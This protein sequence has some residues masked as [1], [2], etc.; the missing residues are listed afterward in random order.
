MTTSDHQFTYKHMLRTH[1]Y[2][3]PPDTE[4]ISECYMK[5]IRPADRPSSRPPV[6]GQSNEDWG[7]NNGARCPT[8]FDGAKGKQHQRDSRSAMWT[9]THKSIPF[10]DSTLSATVSGMPS[11]QAVRR[12]SGHL[13]GKTTA[14]RLP[15]PF[16]SGSSLLLMYPARQD[17]QYPCED[18]QGR[19][20]PNWARPDELAD[21][22]AT[23]G[24]WV[25]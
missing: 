22:A 14:L 16:P 23:T 6:Q 4:H 3:I 9:P 15:P 5:D 20:M 11:G 21:R 7:S 13:I 18:G 1:L 2:A 19:Y 12:H 25:A 8:A 24:E 17:M 10:S